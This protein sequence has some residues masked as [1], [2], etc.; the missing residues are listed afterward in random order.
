MNVKTH[1]VQGSSCVQEP[2]HPSLQ[3]PSPPQSPDLLLLPQAKVGVVLGIMF[4]E[5][6]VALERLACRMQGSLIFKD[7]RESFDSPLRRG[8]CPDPQP[9]GASSAAPAPNWQSFLCHIY[10]LEMRLLHR[11]NLASGLSDTHLLGC[12]VFLSTHRKASRRPVQTWDHAL[13][14]DM[15]VMY[16]ACSKHAASITVGFVRVKSVFCSLTDC[17]R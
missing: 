12:S 10:E 14:L 4:R 3:G 8:S 13:A 17:G 2:R 15:W 7:P 1:R 16:N 9:C 6:G 11:A 5:T